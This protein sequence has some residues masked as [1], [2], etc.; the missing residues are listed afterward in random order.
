MPSYCVRFLKTL[1]NDTGHEV[2]VC[3]TSLEV[4]AFNEQ[5]AIARARELICSRGGSASKL[6]GLRPEVVR[7]EPAPARARPEPL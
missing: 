4:E 3:Q 2:Q 6:W 1:S 5:D 7:L